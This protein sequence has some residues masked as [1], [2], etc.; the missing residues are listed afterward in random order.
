MKRRKIPGHEFAGVVEAVGKDVKR[1][2][3]GDEVFGSTTTL[4]QGSYAEYICVPE[5]RK[6]GGM[7]IKPSNLSFEEA[8]AI[9]KMA[10]PRLCSL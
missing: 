3:K 4:K 6:E 1:F 2:K 8:A 5:E 7:D 9:P 10:V